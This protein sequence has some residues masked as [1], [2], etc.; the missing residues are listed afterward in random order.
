MIQTSL[1]R[2]FHK[3]NGSYNIRT[4]TSK[5]KQ[6]VQKANCSTSIRSLA[7]LE[8]WK[9]LSLNEWINCCILFSIYH[10]KLLPNVQAT[11]LLLIGEVLCS[12]TNFLTQ[13]TFTAVQHFDS[14]TSI[15]TL[16][17]TRSLHLWG[18]HQNTKRH[19]LL[20]ISPFLMMTNNL[21]NSSREWTD[22][23]SMTGVSP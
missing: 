17:R 20:S 8:A 2:F 18:D 10:K 1:K 5:Q 12:F 23:H 11:S 13:T 21:H 14:W 4:I 3:W 6:L 9:T 7:V 19:K 16:Q 15:H 22:I